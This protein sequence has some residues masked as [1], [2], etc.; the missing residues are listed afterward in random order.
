MPHNTGTL[1]MFHGASRRYGAP[2]RAI[3]IAN[4]VSRRPDMIEVDVRVSS[5]G[6][7][8][9][10]HGVWPFSYLL[11]ILSF[12]MLRRMF[13]INTLEDI[14]GIVPLD[15]LLFL[16]LKEVVN[17]D[18]LHRDTRGR[19]LWVASRCPTSLAVL[20]QHMGACHTYVLNR[21]FFSF[22]SLLRGIEVGHPD[23]IKLLWWQMNLKHI[24]VLQQR[25][26]TWSLSRVC[27]PTSITRQLIGTYGSAW[28]CTDTLG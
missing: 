20:R 7:L 6:I 24:K 3:S 18:K 21:E 22:P 19:E 11:C 5:D 2:N 10:L 12:K 23:V 27:A 16:D 17:P 26:I 4:A 15:I 8:Y 25:Q 1:K 9:C 28:Y 13:N 14:S